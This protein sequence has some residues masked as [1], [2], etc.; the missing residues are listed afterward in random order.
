MQTEI[1]LN[2][3]LALEILE[4][5]CVQVFPTLTS[6]IKLQAMHHAL[7]KRHIPYALL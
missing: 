7:P 2:V 3:A 5:F 1:I 4:V 6:Q